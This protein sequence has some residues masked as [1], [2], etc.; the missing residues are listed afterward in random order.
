M[1]TL[2][3]GNSAWKSL[4]N[5]SSWGLIECI[6]LGCFKHHLGEPPPSILAAFWSP[7]IRA[8][9]SWWHDWWSTPFRCSIGGDFEAAHGAGLWEWFAV[10]SR[11]FWLGFLTS[12]FRS[13]CS[14]PAVK[15]PGL[16]ELSG[17]SC[18]NSASRHPLDL[19]CSTVS[20]GSPASSPLCRLRLAN[21]HNS[22]SQF[23]KTSLSPLPSSFLY[24]HA[25][26]HTHTTPYWFCFSEESWLI[27]SSTSP[28]PWPRFPPPWPCLPPV[29]TVPQPRPLLHAHPSLTHPSPDHLPAIPVTHRSIISPQLLFCQTLSLLFIQ[30]SPKIPHHPVKETTVCPP[31]W[32]H[33][34]EQISE[35]KSNVW[36]LLWKLTSESVPHV[37]VRGLGVSQFSALEAGLQG[38][39]PVLH[40]LVFGTCAYDAHKAMILGCGFLIEVLK[41]TALHGYRFYNQPHPTILFIWHCL[42]GKLGKNVWRGQGKSISLCPL[43]FLLGAKPILIQVQCK[44]SIYPIT[45]LGAPQPCLCLAAD[46]PTV[47]GQ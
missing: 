38:G 41:A 37:T 25:H 35:K 18:G 47:R 31:S 15:E 20:P 1:E 44:W 23:L 5:D 29:C 14:S 46:H 28:F 27:H 17:G 19:K 10:L 16:P 22:V 13:Q 3:Y 34:V 39:G 33:S 43:A 26:T 4:G 9:G 24:T 32:V 2:I 12:T 42:P 45:A 36:V 7:A 21:L 30:E 8:L 40:R 11:A 6:S